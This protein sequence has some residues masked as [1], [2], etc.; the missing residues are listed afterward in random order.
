M[1]DG[2][3]AVRAEHAARVCIVHHHDALVLFGKGA[4]LRQGAEV[5]VHAEDAV[6]NQQLALTGWKILQHLAGGVDVLVRK[7]LD[8]RA[9]QS[10]AVDDAGVIE[11]VGNHHVFLG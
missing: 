11:L 9:A 5:A 10:R 4:E 2:A 3:A 7:H 8:R 6:G 1:I